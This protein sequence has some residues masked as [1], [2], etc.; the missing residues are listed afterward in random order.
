MLKKL[1]RFV[2]GSALVAVAVGAS[3]CVGLVV[4]A[5]AGAGG[6]A[7][8]KGVLIQN[9][10]SPLDRVYSATGK[11]LKSMDMTVG[12][13]NKMDDKA[14]VH[15]VFPDGK[16][17]TVELSKL[18]ERSTQIRVRVGWFGDQDR[19]QGILTAIQRHL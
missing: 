5:A 1:R 19:S 10:D 16:K 12:K 14:T 2:L 17:V 11:A 15:S 18:T 8:V 9:V 3:G 6:V 13:E 7:W 4:G